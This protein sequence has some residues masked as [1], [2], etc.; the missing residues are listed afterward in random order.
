MKGTG[1][2]SGDDWSNFNLIAVVK[3]LVFSDE[4]VTFNDQMRFDD[5]IQ[6]AQEFFDFLGTFD[7]DGSGRMTESDLH[8]ES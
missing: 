3:H 8:G 7:L 2:T 1:R 5:K 4:V 6:F